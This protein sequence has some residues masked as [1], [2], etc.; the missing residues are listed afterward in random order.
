VKK[1]IAR[2]IKKRK[3]SYVIRRLKTNVNDKKKWRK[4][5]RKI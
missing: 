2:K 1:K 5:K 3:S 4:R